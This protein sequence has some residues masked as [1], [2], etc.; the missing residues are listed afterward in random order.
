M[1]ESE[2]RESSSENMLSILDQSLRGTESIVEDANN[3]QHL[4]TKMT[5]RE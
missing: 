1:Q 5:T 2:A 3:V 4:K